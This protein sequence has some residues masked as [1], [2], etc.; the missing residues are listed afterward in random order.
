MSDETD[1]RRPSSTGYFISPTDSPGPGVLLLHSF[2]GFD[3]GMKDTANRLA[4]AGFTVLAPD[5][6]DGE[7]FTDH[8][9]ALEALGDADMNH[10]ASLVQSSVGVLRRAQADPTRPIGVVG[11]GAGASWALWLS[12]R[13]PDDILAV[14]TYY[15]SQSIEMTP[16]RSTYLCHWAERDRH[17]DDLEM[18]DLGLRLQMAGRPFRFEHHDGTNDGFAEPGRPEFSGEADVVAWRQTTE[19]LAGALRP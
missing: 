2:W 10:V 17:I 3:R 5:L 1:D 4:D 9:Q 14:A 19:F 8:E 6:A 7:T 13:L 15:G 16:S 11:F 12:A 18:A